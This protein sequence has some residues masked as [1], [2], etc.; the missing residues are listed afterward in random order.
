MY[1]SQQKIRNLKNGIKTNTN[2]IKFKHERLRFR[3]KL[4]N[5]WFL[6]VMQHLA[7]VTSLWTSLGEACWPISAVF[8]LH[9]AGFWFCHMFS[10]QEQM[11]E[12]KKF[13]P[14]AKVIFCTS[15]QNVISYGLKKTSAA[16]DVF[17][18]THKWWC[19]SSKQIC[20]TSVQH[21]K[22]DFSA[23]PFFTAHLEVLS[24]WS[25]A[26]GL[27]KFLF[28]SSTF[29]VSRASCA[30]SSP[31]TLFPA[32]DRQYSLSQRAPFTIPVF[33]TGFLH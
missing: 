6:L 17:S 32:V 15:C 11:A 18:F 23:L 1:N 4:D 19:K 25:F 3:I 14:F 9:M 10:G 26:Q 20:S 2:R 12:F 29:C 33:C 5:R 31:S 7:N 21:L 16:I 28:L 13:K 22:P 27:V 30:L 24:P 8:L